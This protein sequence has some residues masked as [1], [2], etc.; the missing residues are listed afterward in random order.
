MSEK[1]ILVEGGILYCSQSVDKNS[2]ATGVP[3]KVTSQTIVDAN[4]GKL[5]ATPKD[6]SVVNM[7]FGKCNDPKYKVPPPCQ[8]K[9]VWSKMHDG[10]MVGEQELLILTEESEAVCNVCSI[11][12]KIKVAYHGQQATVVADDMATADSEVMENLNPMARP[13]SNLSEKIQIIPEKET[14]SFIVE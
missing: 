1:H 12:G 3:L 4:D 13:M 11:P 9:V 5:V 8:A 10:V 6:D 14:I 2:P 7:N